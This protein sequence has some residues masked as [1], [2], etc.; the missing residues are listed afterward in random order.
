MMLFPTVPMTA[1][2]LILSYVL[3]LGVYS[4]TGVLGAYENGDES[5]YLSN[6][7]PTVASSY[8]SV[9]DPS[10]T[11]PRL[12][13]QCKDTGPA[14]LD[15]TE[16]LIIPD[17]MDPSDPSVGLA[18]ASSVQ[19]QCGEDDGSGSHLSRSVCIVP[20]GVRLIMDGDLNVPALVV[21]GEVIWRDEDHNGEQDRYLC[22]GYVAVEG[23][24]RF[25]MDLQDGGNTGW[26][27]I[28]DNGAVHP[29]GR[30]RFFGGTSLVHHHHGEEV[31]VGNTG[32]GPTVYVAGRTLART[33][34]LLSSPLLAGDVT[35]RLLHSPIRMGWRI[36]DRIG[37]APTLSLSQGWGQ[38]FMVTSVADDGTL[39]L[40]GPALHD[41]MANYVSGTGYEDGERR[42][43]AIMAAEVVNLSRNVI[44]TG[45]DL[46]HV[47]CDPDLPE[48]V[49][50]EQ[51]STEGCRCS[52]FRSMCTLGLHTAQMHSGIMSIKSA[53][54][55]K[56]GQRGVE[57]KYCL[58]LHKLSDCPDCLL[59]DNAV[60][61]GHQRGVV[62]HGTHRSTIRNNVLYDVRGAGIY[63]EDGN[64]MH[65]RIEYNVVVC[66]WPFTDPLYH[67]CTV[68]GTSNHK[69]DASDNQ[70]GIYMVTPAN[71]LIGNRVANS[72]NGMFV[73]ANGQGRGE[74][75]GKVCTNYL[76]F[77][78]WEGE[79]VYRS[80]QHLARLQY[81]LYVSYNLLPRK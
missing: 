23:E 18:S 4:T 48:A 10:V 55:E 7:D 50:G 73:E 32:G 66:P 60:E 35:M 38:T 30:S 65:N 58:H 13:S 64:E 3:L 80:C 2:S 6:F 26:I 36:G 14:F 42:S 31:E 78:R 56:C 27:Y 68:P 77:G 39:E 47:P 25:V 11:P 44:I 69:A 54:V 29:M 74:A 15:G 59:E 33:W 71:D 19:V 17:G 28:K 70:A 81:S 57:G 40:D 51:T 21:H 76:N 12:L 52:S 22:A 5:A 79:S 34:S 61:Y 9:D 67:G 37:V 49:N 75:Y 63:V 20:P 53:R 46:T 62:V 41:Y 1:T 24:G 8:A 16:I 45:D 72:F 43:A